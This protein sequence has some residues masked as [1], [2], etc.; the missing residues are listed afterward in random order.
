MDRKSFFEAVASILN[1]DPNYS[2][3]EYKG[4]ERYLWVRD[5]KSFDTYH[6][7]AADDIV[8]HSYRELCQDPMRAPILACGTG[9]SYV[10]AAG[11]AWLGGG[12]L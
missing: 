10:R 11:L 6:I 4:D 2:H 7:S 12:T 9:S 1:K 8:Q 5:R 3:Y